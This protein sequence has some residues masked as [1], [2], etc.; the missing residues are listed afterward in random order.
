MKNY[1]MIDTA[2]GTRALLMLG[3]EKYYDE[4]L[5]NAGSE[6]L[7]P[8]IDGLLKKAGANLGDIDIFGACVG[9]GSFTGLRIGLT[10]IKTFCYTLNKPCFGVNNLR[11]NSY[12][13]NSGKVISV[14]D[15]GNKVCYI[16]RFD[17]DATLDPAMCMTLDDALVFVKKH[18]DFSVSTDNKLAGIFSGTVGVTA[19]ELAIAAEKFMGKELSY[20]ELQPLYIRKAQPERGEGDL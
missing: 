2:E 16:A 7:M 4:N 10:T 1:L 8:M 11:L 6:T 5:S 20:K 12:N 17:G 13:N 18:S 15:A 9:P 14:A 19:R 3:G